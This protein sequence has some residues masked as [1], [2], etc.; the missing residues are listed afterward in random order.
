MLLL[1]LSWCA[2]LITCSHRA[3]IPTCKCNS[4]TRASYGVIFYWASVVQGP[5][6]NER[7]QV[8]DRLFLTITTR[9]VVTLL[10]CFVISH[11]IAVFLADG[12]F[13]LCMILLQIAWCDRKA[14]P[15]KGFSL[16]T[17]DC[18]GST[19]SWKRN[20]WSLYHTQGADRVLQHCWQ[21]EF[22]IFTCAS[23]LMN[24][25]LVCNFSSF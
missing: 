8:T 25:H 12:S 23:I 9:K 3:C 18:C 10:Q 17:H 21:G 16:A 1:T 15:T 5:Y 20:S 14:E 24:I 2:C 13:F 11:V 6:L 22:D 19:N 4:K 7:E